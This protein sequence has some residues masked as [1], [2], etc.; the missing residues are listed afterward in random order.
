MSKWPAIES[1]PD[2][3]N[4]FASSLGLDTTKWSFCDVMGLDE[5]LLSFLPQP[6]LALIFLFPSAAKTPVDESKKQN[7]ELFYLQQVDQLQDACGT[8]AMIHALANNRERVGLTSGVLADYLEKAKT[9][10]FHD[11]GVALATDSKIAELHKSFSQEGAT[12]SVE[13]GG[14]DHHFV[15]FT[16]IGDYVVEID[17]CKPHAVFHEKVGERGFLSVAAETIKKEYM[18]DPSIIDFSITALASAVEQN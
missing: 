15:C 6:T 17:G 14:T 11:K 13:V 3:L 18:K 5:E 9:L 12:R 1:N 10:S 7:T 2:V 4:S 8:I 16:Q